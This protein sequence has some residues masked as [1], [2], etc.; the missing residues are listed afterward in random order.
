MIVLSCYSAIP[1]II[2]TGFAA[3]NPIY[4][5]TAGPDEVQSFPIAQTVC[6]NHFVYVTFAETF[7][8][9]SLLMLDT[10]MF[11]SDIALYFVLGT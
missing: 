11:F 5:F 7:Y 8:F 1:K 10:S 9:I 4:F 3:I 6:L 2:K